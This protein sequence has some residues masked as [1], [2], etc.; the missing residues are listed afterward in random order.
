MVLIQ[1]M[2]LS[3]RQEILIDQFT[4]VRNH[5][6]MFEPQI[7][8]VAKLVF[9]FYLFH[10]DDVL[11][12]NAKGSVF[13]I[14]WLVRDHISGCQGN[15]GVLDSSSDTDGSFM[16]VEVRTNSMSCAMAVVESLLLYIVSEYKC[17][18]N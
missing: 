16:H 5:G 17:G 18:E 10:H 3:P 12:T 11:N 9:C 6:D 8:L 1:P 7:C 14:S 2:L 13:I 4:T 15:F